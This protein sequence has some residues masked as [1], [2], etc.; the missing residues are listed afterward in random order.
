MTRTKHYSWKFRSYRLLF[1]NR[2]G[3]S[4]SA[5]RSSE[6]PTDGE[7][8]L[9]VRCVFPWHLPVLCLPR[10]KIKVL[11]LWDEANINLFIKYFTKK[12]EKSCFCSLYLFIRSVWFL[13]SVGLRL[14]STLTLLT[15]L[16]SLSLSHQSCT[17]SSLRIEWQNLNIQVIS[18]YLKC[19]CVYTH[20]H[21]YVYS[22]N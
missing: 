19:V 15:S 8:V 17:K 16:H 12:K 22:S 2:W 9:K 11:C 14:R 3:F 4:W 21:M 6:K 20:V 10:F 5:R 18:F 1:L 13:R 7:I